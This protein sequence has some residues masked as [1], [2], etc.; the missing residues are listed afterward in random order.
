MKKLTVLLLCLVL[1]LPLAACAPS[2]DAT[3]VVRY[4]LSNAW[5]TLMPYNSPSGSN[6]TR[7]VC[8]KLY[9]RLAYVH[10]DGT[11]DPRNAAAWESADGGMAVL[12]FLDEGAAFHDG[13]PVTA[14]HWADTIALMTD[15]DCPALGRSVFNVLAGTD[16]AGAAL[17]GE[18]LG[19]EAVDTYTLKLTF[20][21]P[22]TPED[23]LLDRNREF[24]VLPTHLLEGTDPAE[25]L[26]LPLWQA[27][28]GSGPLTFVE[29]IPG[30]QLTLAANPNY[31]LG[32]P[33]FDLLVITVMD[34]SNLLPSLIAG[35]LD[36]YAFG[37]NLAADDRQTAE[38]GGITVLEGTVPNSFY[39][40]M[41]NN[42]RIS[43]SAVRR[44][45]DLALDKQALCLHT[46]QGLGEPTA[47]DLTPGTAYTSSLTW[48]RDVEGAMA[49]L[50]EGG[51]DGRTYSLA[52]TANRSGLAA[53]M[54][55]QLA[56]A[57]ITTT[58]ETVDSAALFSGMAEGTYDMAIASHTPGA[59]PLWFTES[60]FSPGNNIFHVADLTPYTGLISQIKAASD[61]GARQALVDELQALLARER[62]FLPLWFGRTLH[63]QSPTVDN[64]DY[65]S[66]SFSN[67]NVWEWTLQAG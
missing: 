37:G 59:L 38:A 52:C 50:E 35:D 15:P 22:T 57:G 55:Q 12:F 64:I 40:L 14:Q 61:S 2:R 25:V 24:Y 9:D 10:A 53:L 63:A 13:T 47:T 36:Y 33:G 16:E 4:G 28:V 27:P 30:S 21:T 62:P 23:F 26:E 67:E 56:Q 41:L 31:Q 32:R 5:D 43:S 3:A 34:K 51:Y 42:E 1:A 49:L 29:E 19:A 11:L 6:Y 60:R 20:K 54:Q 46:A 65:P 48:S 58:I 44:A 17:P 39:E 18:A 7:I 45:I 66:S 8:D